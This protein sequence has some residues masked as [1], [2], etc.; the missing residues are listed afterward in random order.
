MWHTAFLVLSC[1]FLLTGCGSDADSEL[2]EF[3]TRPVVLPDGTKIT[4]EV[5]TRPADM[6]R[7]MMFRDALPDG[8]GMLFV[9]GSPGQYSYWM[10]QVKVPLDI[11]WMDARGRIV[12]IAENVPP[13]K[14]AA[15]ECPSYGGKQTSLVVLELPG[16]YGRRHGVVLGDVIRF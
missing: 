5:M 12:E 15:S 8:E 6:Q 2:R 1:V 4:A 16:G 9:H 7:G 11:I 14:T 10:Y 13:C 3:N